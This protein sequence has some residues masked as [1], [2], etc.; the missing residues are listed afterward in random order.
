M[1]PRYAA[2]AW[3]RISYADACE[4]SLSAL[5]NIAGRSRVAA[6]SISD[7]RT[8]DYILTAIHEHRTAVR[9][10]IA[11]LDALGH[12]ANGTS[13]GADLIVDNNGVDIVIDA[14]GIHDKI[15]EVCRFACYV[16]AGISRMSSTTASDIPFGPVHIAFQTHLVFSADICRHC[17]QILAAMLTGSSLSRSR[18]RDAADAGVVSTIAA[19]MHK[20]ITNEDVCKSGGDALRALSEA[21]QRD[22]VVDGGGIGALVA[23]VCACSGST[24]C[25]GTWTLVDLMN[26]SEEH[27]RLVVEA[28]GIKAI[29]RPAL[30]PGVFVEDHWEYSVLFYV[31]RMVYNSVVARNAIV[32][33]KGGLSL[34]IRSVRARTNVDRLTQGTACGTLYH[35]AQ[36]QGMATFTSPAPESRL[37][38]IVDAGGLE[39]LAA[40]QDMRS[41]VMWITT[42]TVARL[43][44]NPATAA[45]RKQRFDLACK[46]ERNRR[47]RWSYVR[48]WALVKLGRATLK[49]DGDGW[50]IWEMAFGVCEKTSLPDDVQRKVIGVI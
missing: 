11:G 45:E 43:T 33:E 29:L 12:V 38:A 4:E 40:A 3:D 14:L 1:P 36:P 16:L 47:V 13:G 46:R 8:I 10:S 50:H 39:A 20:H 22:A 30:E 5:G 32:Q 37:D 41:D 17:C 6:E 49:H 23:T 18:S 34:V 26:A 2:D 44:S 21:G 15:T 24:W 31:E 25:S 19:A 7:C 9:V 42:E 48:M 27:A 35:L 28:N